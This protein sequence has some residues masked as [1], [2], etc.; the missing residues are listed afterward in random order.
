MGSVVRGGSTAVMDSMRLHRRP[1][2]VPGGS[3][4]DVDKLKRLGVGD[5]E[6]GASWGPLVLV[7]RHWAYVGMSVGWELGAS[8]RGAMQGQGRED[9]IDGPLWVGRQCW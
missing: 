3:R 1:D 7:S 6:M 8:S 5:E 2:F 4:R 9:F